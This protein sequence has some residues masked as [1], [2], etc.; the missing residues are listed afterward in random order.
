[1]DSELEGLEEEVQAI[2][3]DCYVGAMP[4]SHVG[5]ALKRRELLTLDDDVEDLLAELLGEDD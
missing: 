5:A 3:T 4:A 2:L 1:M